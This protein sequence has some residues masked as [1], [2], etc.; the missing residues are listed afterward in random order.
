MQ[1]EVGAKITS[2]DVKD[3]EYVVNLGELPFPLSEAQ[4][5]ELQAEL[6]DD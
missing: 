2:L 6:E 4:K 3:D 1:D 5:E